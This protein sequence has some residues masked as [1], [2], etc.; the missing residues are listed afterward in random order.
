MGSI[1][2]PSVVDV[3]VSTVKELLAFTTLPYYQVSGVLASGQGAVVIGDPVAWDTSTKKYI[4]FDA[5]ETQVTNEAVGTGNGT[6]KVYQLVNGN[7]IRGSVTVAVADRGAQVEN[8]DYQLDYETGYLYFKVAP[9]NTKAITATY[10]W[11]ENAEEAAGK[12]AGFVR[13]PG[14]ATSADVPIEVVIGG[15]VKYSVIS[16]ATEYSAKILDDLKAKYFEVA[17]AVIF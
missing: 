12:C 4:K 7:V 1:K 15:A 16:A 5:N 11:S 17:D 9:E 6:L 10:K 13:I 14:D 8:V 2:L 3:A